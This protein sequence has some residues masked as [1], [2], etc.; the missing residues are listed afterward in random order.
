M[1]IDIH[2]PPQAAPQ[3]ALFS[4]SNLQIK[5]Q[6]VRR[7]FDFFVTAS[8]RAS[9]L[10]EHFANV[11]IPKPIP[12]SRRFR[13]RKNAD[14]SVPR[15]KSHKQK[16]WIPQQPHLCFPLSIR[17]LALPV[18]AKANGRRRFPS[19]LRR[20]SFHVNRAS[21]ANR[22]RGICSDVGHSEFF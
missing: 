4:G 13:I 10:Q 20:K 19:P 6:S 7:Q 12:S 3:I 5:P 15:V 14:A 2:P 17:V 11:A 1:L 21:H 22:K 16:L 8:M 9:R 18:G